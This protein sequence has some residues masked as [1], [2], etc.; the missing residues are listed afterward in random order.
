MFLEIKNILRKYPFIFNPIRNVYK[1][2]FLGTSPLQKQIKENLEHKTSVFFCQVGS[3]D[4]LHGDPI[5]DL[6]TKN[7]IWKGIFVEPV[8]YLFERL[9]H[10]Y[11]KS[12]RFIYE[13]KA[14][15]NRRDKINFYYV[16]NKAKS[17]LG[18]A[19]PDWYDQL[20]SFD[21]NHIL[22]HLDGKLEPY[23]ITEKVDTIP[24]QEIFKKYKVINLDL[25]HIDTEGYDYKI[26][27]QLDF[28]K[29]KP[30]LILFEHKHLSEE[31]KNKA[32]SLLKLQNYKCYYH[33]SDTLAIFKKN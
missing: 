23:I 9:K 18:N 16:S 1:A 30:T 7:K 21:K 6:I 20:G 32:I 19:L 26:L 8:G 10:T 24:L 15:A 3:N 29:Y 33:G 5:H 11:G 4:G 13:N 2:Y 22:K 14:I 31:E 25:L 17:E 27:S 28:S 12:D